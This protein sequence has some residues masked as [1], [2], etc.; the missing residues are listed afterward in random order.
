MRWLRRR[1]DLRRLAPRRVALEAELAQLFRAPCTLVPAVSKG[2]YDQ[3]FYAVSGGI[4]RAVVRVNNPHRKPHEAVHPRLPL[5][6]LAPAARLAR[7]WDA[8]SRLFPLGLAPQPLWRTGDAMAC[9][10]VDRTR[11]SA[12]LTRQHAGV[13]SFAATAF[14]AVRRMH[15]AGVVHLDLN[16]GNLLFQSGDDRLQF[17]DFEYGPA[18]WVSV[19][20]QMAYDYLRLIDD[21]LRPRRIGRLLLADP[22]RLLARVRDVIPAPVAQARTGFAFA[23]LRQLAANTGFCHK[24]SAIFPALRQ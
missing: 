17:I 12:A 14:P 20:Q 18:D 10:W 3:I 11:A 6:A 15:E 24:L 23:K 13:W 1:A 16:L 7:E 4:R 22:E 8:Y 5:V 9:S 21:L 2:G 19:E